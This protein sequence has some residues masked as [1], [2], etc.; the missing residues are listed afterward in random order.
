MKIHKKYNIKELLSKLK[1]L[2]LKLKNLLLKLFIRLLKRIFSIYLYSRRRCEC[3]HV[4]I[5]YK[6]H[7]WESGWGRHSKLCDYCH[8]VCYKEAQQKNTELTHIEPKTNESKN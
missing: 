6:Q 5:P 4:K 8:D 2:I 3:C 7:H 1:T